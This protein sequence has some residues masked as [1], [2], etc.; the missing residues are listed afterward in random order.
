MSDQRH[1]EARR[2]RTHGQDIRSERGC[3]SGREAGR[4]RRRY[5]A[6]HPSQQQRSRNPIRPRR[7]NGK[8]DRNFEQG[9]LPT[10][11]EFLNLASLLQPSPP[12]PNPTQSTTDLIHPN[13]KIA[14]RVDQNTHFEMNLFPSQLSHRHDEYSMSLQQLQRTTKRK[15]NKNVTTKGESGKCGY[16]R[17]EHPAADSLFFGQVLPGTPSQ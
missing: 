6:A 4:Q 7:K 3:E 12:L 5:A 17:Y 14:H 10:C 1:S 9:K 13:E 8:N 11:S 15:K 2:E 16:D